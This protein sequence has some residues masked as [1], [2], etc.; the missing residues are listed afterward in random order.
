VNLSNWATIEL[1]RHFRHCK[2]VLDERNVN[3]ED[4]SWD[5]S[6]VSSEASQPHIT[7]VPPVV[8]VTPTTDTTGSSSLKSSTRNPN[9]MI[10]DGVLTL[11][12]SSDPSIDTTI[13]T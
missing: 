6:L 9:S 4:T 11:V 1:V 12:P 3:P 8:S 7:T 5:S 10:T 2:K 13:K